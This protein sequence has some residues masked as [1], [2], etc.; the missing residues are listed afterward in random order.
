MELLTPELGL[1]VWTL[2]SFLSLV[3]LVIAL[4]MFL[5][6]NYPNPITKLVWT[7]VIMFVPT[8]GPIL[9]LAIGRQRSHKKVIV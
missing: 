2:L 7:L 1:L 9:F 6:T 8:I 4:I 3:L 5:R